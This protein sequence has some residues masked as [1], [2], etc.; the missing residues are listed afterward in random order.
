MHIV[1]I[2]TKPDIIKQAPIYKELKRRG[3]LVLLCHTGQ[4]Y[5]FRNSKAIL[6]ELEMKVDL[7]F[8]VKGTL[9]E[10]IGQII[11]QTS[12][13]I[14]GLRKSG[15]IIIPY[16]HG[17]TLTA[18]GVA[19]GAILERVA[20]VHVE[21]ELRTMTP[22][23]KIYKKHLASY[24]AGKFN[25]ETYRKDLRKLEN[26]EIGSFEPF[27][28]QIDTR[29]IDE[30]AAIRLAPNKLNS[31]LLEKER[32]VAS[33]IAVVGNTISDAVQT[34]LNKP[35]CDP[36]IAKMEFEGRI[37]FTIH[38]RETCEDAKRFKIILEVLERILKQRKVLLIAHPMFL[39]GTRLHE[40][41]F[42]R[43][44]RE[45]HENLRILKPIPYHTDTIKV[46]SR[47]EAVVTD[48]GGVQ[49]EAN[50]LGKTCITLRYGT[51]RVESVVSGNNILAPLVDSGFIF[52]IVNGALTVVEKND[53]ALYGKDVAKQIVDYVLSHIDNETGLFRT[54]EQ[55]LQLLCQ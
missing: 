12:L 9:A 51:D 15:K 29:I 25:Y 36:R 1:F 53:Q 14:S 49:E 27:P 19:M 44:R 39:N 50:I 4:H 47:C 30:V 23:E 5:D 40:K 28:E 7:N 10:K 43:I 38:R 32:G 26:F 24:C 2:G 46:I 45:Y 33:G 34:A 18:C 54:E 35:F 6:D 31:Q 52:D 21:A 17:D 37:F 22:K 16:V 11:N 13:L 55:R 20:P 3:E 42:V 41:D 8:K 48:S